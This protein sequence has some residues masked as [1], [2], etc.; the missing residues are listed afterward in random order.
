MV[1]QQKKPDHVNK[2]NGNG[3]AGAMQTLAKNG[4]PVVQ[5]VIAGVIILNTYMT[6]QN[7]N[8]IKEADRRL[9][10][11]RESVARQVKVIYDNQRF[12]FDFVDEVRAS[13]DRIQTKLG[14]EHPTIT[15]YPRQELPELQM[16][17]YTPYP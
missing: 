6:K 8:G 11:L 7:G 10:F 16:Y 17:P 12:H 14:I 5:L 13:Q 4:G 2:T 1:K 15:P 3:I 9:D